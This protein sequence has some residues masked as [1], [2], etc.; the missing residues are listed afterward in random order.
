MPAAVTAG[1][2]PDVLKQPFRGPPDIRPHSGISGTPAPRLEGI[3]PSVSKSSCIR[4][5]P[6]LHHARGG[7]H[8]IAM[9]GETHAAILDLARTPVCHPACLRQCLVEHR[10]C[11]GI[12]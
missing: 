3:N 11:G 7:L 6:G 10:L 2:F 8:A 12:G 9:E 4:E 1:A 5:D